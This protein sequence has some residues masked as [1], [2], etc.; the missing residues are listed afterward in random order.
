MQLPPSNEEI[1]KHVAEK[2]GDFYNPS[3]LHLAVDTS[4]KVVGKSPNDRYMIK[5]VTGK[6]SFPATKQNMEYLSIQVGKLGY[7]IV[8]DSDDYSKLK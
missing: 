6:D 3:Q 8:M 4:G 5:R 1:K 2:F 7:E